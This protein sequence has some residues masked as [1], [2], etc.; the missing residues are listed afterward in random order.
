MS[1]EKS[2][3]KT[4]IN[5][6]PGHMAKTKRLIGEKLSQIDV[7]YELIDARIPYS[8]KIV[9]IDDVVKNKPKILIMTKYDLC[10]KKE[11]NKWVKHYENLGYKV[12]CIEPETK[13]SIILNATKELM[14]EKTESLLEKGVHKK[15][16]RVLIVGIPNVG[17][18]TLINKLV[19]KKAVTVGNKPGITKNL[20]WIRINDEV[21][22]LDT[23][24]ILWPK[25]EDKAV[26]DKLAFIGSVKDEILDSEVLA[27][28]LINVLKNGYCDQITERFKI[29]GFEELEDYEILEMIG[30]KRGR[31]ADFRR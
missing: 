26:G 30:R 21:E 12:L 16:I 11:T 6:Y 22:L 15:K 25:F 19:G 3:P 2:F 9:D 29:T 31:Y 17:K 10:D 20:D 8:S 4:S 14:R 27:M 1:E 23:P 28:R 5:W 13:I 7:V 18:S 24:G